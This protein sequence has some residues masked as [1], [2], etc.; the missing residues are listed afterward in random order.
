VARDRPQHGEA[1][2]GRHFIAL[3]PADAPR[4]GDAGEAGGT[5]AGDTIKWI[6]PLL[7][8]QRLTPLAELMLLVCEGQDRLTARDLFVLLRFVQ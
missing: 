3:A 1:H 6:A 5:G 7:T 8:D 4:L 2:T